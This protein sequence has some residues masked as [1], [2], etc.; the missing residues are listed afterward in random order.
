MN[1]IYGG[2]SDHIIGTE[3]PQSNEE[4]SFSLSHIVRVVIN[5]LRNQSVE[6]D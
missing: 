2:T 1:I 6:Q 4:A 5:V 3:E